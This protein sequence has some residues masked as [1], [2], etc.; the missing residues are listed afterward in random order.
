MTDAHPFSTRRGRKLRRRKL[1]ANP[2]C[3]PCERKRK[4]TVATEVHHVRPLCEG[5]APYPELD[6]LESRC[7]ACHDQVHGARPRAAVDPA[8]GLP[9]GGDHWWSR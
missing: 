4:V 6:G 7:H 3:E 1:E 9:I 5:G 8:T 2:L